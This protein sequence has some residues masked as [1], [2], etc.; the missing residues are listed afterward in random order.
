V[1]LGVLTVNL[2]VIDGAVFGHYHLRCCGL[3]VERLAKGPLF[4]PG[5]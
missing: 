5:A 4:A 3:A 2:L 1:I